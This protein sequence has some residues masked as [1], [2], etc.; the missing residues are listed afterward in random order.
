MRLTPEI[1]KRHNAFWRH[2]DVKTPIL[3]VTVANKNAAWD[4]HAPKT[5]HDKWENIETRFKWSMFQMANHKCFGDAF[6]H[7]FINFGPGCMAAMLGSDYVL[8]DNSVWFGENVTFID[9]WDKL[10]DLRLMEDS[11]MYRLVE[12]MTVY[13]GERSNGE[14]QVSITDPGGQLGHTG[15]L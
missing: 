13:Y 7:E 6:S 12:D 2:E 14:Y 3:F 4:E 11:P 8:T 5:L 10:G 15:V 9:D 1:M